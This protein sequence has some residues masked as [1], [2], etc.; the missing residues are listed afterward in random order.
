VHSSEIREALQEPIQQIV[1]AVRRALE[2]TPPELASDIVDRGII[3]TGGGALIRGLDLLLSQE[4]GLPIHVDEDP[5]TCVVRGAGRILDD[6][7]K[8]SSVLAT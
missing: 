7:E 3:M 8:Y 1:D 6:F 5:L 2:I 4:T